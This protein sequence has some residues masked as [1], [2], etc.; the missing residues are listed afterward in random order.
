MKRA[1]AEISAALPRSAAGGS[2]FQVIGVRGS[3][4]SGLRIATVPAQRQDDFAN[5]KTI[6]MIGFSL[7][8]GINL[9]FPEEKQ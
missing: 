9:K 1:P 7:A 6:E 2:A 8:S 4:A 3:H 5:M